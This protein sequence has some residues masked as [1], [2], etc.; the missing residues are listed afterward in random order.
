MHS[1]TVYYPTLAQIEPVLGAWAMSSIAL[2]LF[3]LYAAVVSNWTPQR[4]K[5][6]ANA[7]FLAVI[8]PFGTIAAFIADSVFDRF[9]SDGMLYTS[10]LLVLYFVVPIWALYLVPRLL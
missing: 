8:N 1:I 9:K 4:Y 7:V 2:A 6:I 3:L 10:T 5:N